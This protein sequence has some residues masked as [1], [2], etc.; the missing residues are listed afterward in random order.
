[1]VGEEERGMLGWNW[2]GGGFDG[3]V[4]EWGLGVGGSE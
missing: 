3:G 1:M 4:G 2:G